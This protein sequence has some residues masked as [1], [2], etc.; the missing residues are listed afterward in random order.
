[1]AVTDPNELHCRLLQTR[2]VRTSPSGGAAT[3]PPGVGA[4]GGRGWRG[5]SSSSRSRSRSETSKAVAA[6][7]RRQGS[8]PASSPAAGATGAGSETIEA[9]PAPAGRPA[10]RRKGP[11]I[12]LVLR[13]PTVAATTRR[14][15]ALALPASGSRRQPPEPAGLM[16]AWAPTASW[17][18]AWAAQASEGGRRLLGPV[19]P[20]Q[21][22]PTTPA[23]I[24]TIAPRTSPVFGSVIWR[25]LKPRKEF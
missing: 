5:S 23:R 18:A 21:A 12:P 9:E 11:L 10:R 3:G 4:R 14:Y 8:S 13:V 20:P 17:V 7:L 1:M 19:P 22:A 2:K 16:I 24:P 15:W 6:G 25:K